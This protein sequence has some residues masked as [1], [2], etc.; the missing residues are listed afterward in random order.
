MVEKPATTGTR[1]TRPPA[2]LDP[3]GAHDAVA[4]VVGAFDEDVRRE[5]LDQRQRRVLVEQDHAIHGGEAGEHPGARLLARHRP[6]GALAE[7]PDRGVGVEADHERVALAPGGLEQ[8]DVAGVQQVEHAVGEHD[9][10]P[11]AARARRRP[12]PASES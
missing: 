12:R 10:A 11:L 4:R 9:R 2:G 5:R 6:R 7:P 8:L 1:T 3:V